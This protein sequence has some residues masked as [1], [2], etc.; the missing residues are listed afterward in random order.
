[1]SDLKFITCASAT[2]Y[3]VYE[4]L[5]VD[6]LCYLQTLVNV[7]PKKIRLPTSFTFN[8]LRV[9]S[10]AFE[11]GRDIIQ[12]VSSCPHSHIYNLHLFGK[13]KK[14]PEVHQFSSNL[15]KLT[16]FY[17]KLEEDPMATLE[18]LPNLKI[19]RLFFFFNSFV[20]KNM[21]C[22]EIGFP[23]LQSLVL[24]WLENLEEW[25]VEEGAMPSLCRLQ[26]ESCSS[27]RTIPEGLRFVATLRELEIK[28]MPKTFK[29]RVDKG[30]EDFCKVQNV[31]SLVFQD[32][33]GDGDGE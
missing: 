14:L 20:G 32:S 7:W 9:R 23:Q 28:R 3:K 4:K 24:N 2:S 31:P 33:D 10:Y 18:K 26:I 30:G 6:N 19:L 12:I 8:R 15:A 17:S 5:E 21:V 29:D 22:S 11:S 27:L 25:R 13:I 1:M 16:L